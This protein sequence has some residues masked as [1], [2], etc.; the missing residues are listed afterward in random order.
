MPLTRGT[1]QYKGQLTTGDS[2]GQA[3]SLHGDLLVA[4]TETGVMVHERQAPTSARSAWNRKLLQQPRAAPVIGWEGYELNIPD[5]MSSGPT[6]DYIF[7]VSVAAGKDF[8]AVGGVGKNN[9]SPGG[10]FIYTA[11]NSWTDPDTVLTPPA[12]ATNDFGRIVSVSGTTV[13][14]AD[15]GQGQVFVYRLSLSGWSPPSPVLPTTDPNGPTTWTSMTLDG[16]TIAIASTAFTKVFVMSTGSGPWTQKATL[17]GGANVHLSGLTLAIDGTIYTRKGSNWVLTQKLGAS[18][19]YDHYSVRGIDGDL[20]IDGSI[21][22]GMGFSSSAFIRNKNTGLWD[23][24]ARLT[25]PGLSDDPW[26]FYG[27]RGAVSGDVI[28][29]A[30]PGWGGSTDSAPSY[31]AVYVFDRNLL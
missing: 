28:V 2:F 15:P 19:L 29:V 21:T 20:L 3:L 27:Y 24:V 25:V 31:G 18:S 22:P 7:G 12:G 5:G 30:A 6:D 16:S 26:T 11:K 14:V 23:K 10:A 17:P 4:A 9:T 8:V 13:A 1:D